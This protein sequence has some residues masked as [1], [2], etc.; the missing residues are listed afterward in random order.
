MDSNT[1]LQRKAEERFQKL[2]WDRLLM[3]VYDS[4]HDYANRVCR[5]PTFMDSDWNVGL[6]EVSGQTEL[7]VGM[8]EGGD[9]L[10]A[11]FNDIRFKLAG[12]KTVEG[13]RFSFDPPYWQYRIKL[14][15]DNSEKI[16]AI[17]HCDASNEFVMWRDFRFVTL[18]AFHMD[19][20]VGALLGSLSAAIDRKKSEREENA[21][22][23]REAQLAGK[24]SL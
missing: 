9:T 10:V 20:R 15:L 12:V 18:N 7:L 23:K 4:V 5:D 22:A 8:A 11:T 2:K 14:F 6:S 1:T 13:G 16:D 24:F 17:Y 3:K 19:E 21:K